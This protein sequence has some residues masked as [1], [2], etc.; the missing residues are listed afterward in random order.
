LPV[1]ADSAKV[2]DSPIRLT[3]NASTEHWPSISADGKKLLFSS[4][5]SGKFAFWLKNLESGTEM[6]LTPGGNLAL[7]GEIGKDGNKFS[8][9]TQDEGQGVAHRMDLS[10]GETEM[11]CGN[12][13]YEG[14]TSDESKIL[15][16]TAE[17]S[18]IMLRDVA[19]GADAE[20][21]KHSKFDLFQPQLSSD[22][23]WMVFY[24]RIGVERSRIFLVPFRGGLTTPEADWVPVTA[25]D[26][27]ETAPAWAPGGN[28]LYFGSNR[29]GFNCIWARRLDPETKRPIEPAFGL[30]H[31]HTAARRLGNVG[32]TRRGM[33]V[34]RDKIVF[35]V[36]ER[37]GNI[38]L[39]R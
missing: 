21:L 15:Y 12:C 31:F 29:D 5:R 37:T 2:R 22:N 8:Y 28:I 18:R 6:A 14:H 16:V 39:I 7:Y 11:L 34:G 3:D 24:A 20:L 30:A 23:R 26:A 36:E 38:W 33:S 25:G 10:S 4:T 13:L 27:H 1:D 19:S 9:Y 17:P 32:V 35:T